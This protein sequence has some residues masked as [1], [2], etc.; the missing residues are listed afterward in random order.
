MSRTTSRGTASVSLLCEALHVSRQAYYAA[1]RSP[2]PPPRRP[3]CAPQG[4]H[5]PTSQAIPAIRAVAARF[6]A[7]GVRKVWA[8]VRRD[9]LRVSR[10]RVWV[11]MATLGLLQKAVSVRGEEV[12]RG[13]VAVATSNRRWATDMTK[14][15][16]RLDGWVAVMPVIDCGDRV[17][18]ACE[19]SQSQ[20]SGAL[21][22]P[23]A[24][25]LREHVGDPSRVPDGLELRT[26][27][28]PQYT[29]ADAA[30]LCAAWR[31]EHTFAPVGRP[32]GNAVAE[33]IMLTMKV[34]LIWTRD[35]ESAEELRGAL[36][37]W[38]KTYN[39]ERPHQSLGW[40]T[41][42]ERRTANLGRIAAA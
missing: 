34:E 18:L 20:T 1:Q 24:L 19:T 32:T 26:D 11:L 6:P 14:A 41:P 17:L 13:T 40:Q 15:W 37:A 22:A 10:R 31:L 30:E 35:W 29:G 5:T 8:C 36:R 23:V 9:G 42:A 27:H 39:E 2:S 7:W 21:L 16:T 28:G 12:P 38:M 4:D 33:R 25:A 3:R